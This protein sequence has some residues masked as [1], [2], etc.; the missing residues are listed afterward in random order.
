MF[1]YILF[2][3]NYISL[4]FL[5]RFYLIFKLI[6][7]SSMFFTF[8]QFF[9]IFLALIFEKCV[10]ILKQNEDQGQ[11]GA[12]GNFRKHSENFAELAKLNFH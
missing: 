4:I 2:Y 1:Y 12:V 6:F 8:L 5:L 10:Q 7:C 11:S 9:L 3:F